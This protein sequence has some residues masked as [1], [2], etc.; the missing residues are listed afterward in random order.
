MYLKTYCEA[1]PTRRCKFNVPVRD[2]L[3]TSKMKWVPLSSSLCAQ[4]NVLSV[5]SLEGKH[6]EQAPQKL[7]NFIEQAAYSLNSA[8]DVAATSIS[9]I[10]AQAFVT[11]LAGR[12]IRFL[13]FQHFFKGIAI[14]ACI[15]IGEPY[16]E[17][18]AGLHV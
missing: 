2:L 7:K 11:I 10:I 4:R 6:P 9:A 12:P 17:L 16:P 5:D 8:L 15:A 3:F 18:D 1:K 14:H 13:V